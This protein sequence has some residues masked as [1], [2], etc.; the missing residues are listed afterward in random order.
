MISFQNNRQIVAVS[1]DHHELV[2]LVATRMSQQFRLDEAF[3]VDLG[4]DQPFPSACEELT[5]KLK[6]LSVQKYDL[7]IAL[8]RTQVNHINM[9]SRTPPKRD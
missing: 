5:N 7:L 2:C 3:R 1:W 4:L 9:G 8:P 6:S